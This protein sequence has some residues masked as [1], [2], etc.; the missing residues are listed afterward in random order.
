MNQIETNEREV[1][2]GWSRQRSQRIQGRFLRGPISLAQLSA[3][4]KLPGQA[5]SVYLA[6]HH[7]S[8]LTRRARVVLPRSL[9]SQLGIS[10][11]AKSRALR[12]LADAGLIEIESARG[13]TTRVKLSDVEASR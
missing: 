2:T 6:V 10:R 11:D 9:M 3:A 8:A 12:Q 5:L 4:A 7:Q 1:E 13:R